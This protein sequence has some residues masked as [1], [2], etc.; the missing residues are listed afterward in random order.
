MSKALQCDR[1]GKYFN[2][3]K[4]GLYS[5]FSNPLCYTKNDF[6]NKTFSG[7]LFNS[8]KDMQDFQHLNLCDECTKNLCEFMKRKF[9]DYLKEGDNNEKDHMPE[10]RNGDV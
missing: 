2:P 6:K 1:C 9:P 10:M 3:Q 8:T 5:E 4:I 7:V